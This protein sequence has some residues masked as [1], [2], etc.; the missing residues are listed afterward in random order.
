MPARKNNFYSIC[1]FRRRPRLKSKPATKNTS[2]QFRTTYAQIFAVKQRKAKDQRSGRR[3]KSF[4]SKKSSAASAPKIGPIT[5]PNNSSISMPPF[6]GLRSPHPNPGLA[7]WAV[8]SRPF[9]AKHFTTAKTPQGWR[10]K[11][12]G[13]SPERA[14]QRRR[15]ENTT[16]SC[17]W[18]RPR[19]MGDCVEVFRLRICRFVLFVASFVLVPIQ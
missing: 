12:Q 18:V 16:F 13:V 7:P 8:L 6:Q 14:A 5:V 10:S 11:A 2:G 19:C 1:L 3:E 4:K 9:R 15:D 17:A